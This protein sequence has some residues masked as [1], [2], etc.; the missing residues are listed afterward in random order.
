MTP[1]AAQ[2]M[3][4]DDP[5]SPDS[6]SLERVRACLGAGVPTGRNDEDSVRRQWWA[7]LATLQSDCLLP[8]P[9]QAG[10]W[11]A[12][13]LPALYEPELLAR[14]RGWVWAPPQ[15]QTLLGAAPPLLA[16]AGSRPMPM[17]SGFERLPLGPDDGTDPLLIVITPSLQVA[18]CLDGPSTARRLVARFEP[19]VLSEAL[20]L[21]HARLAATTP[22]SAERLEQAMRTLGPLQSDPE[23]GLRFWPQLADRLAAMAPSVTLQ[24]LVQPSHNQSESGMEAVSGELALLE[25]LT[26]EVRT[27]LAT[28]RTLIRS[29]LRRRDLSTVVRQRLEHIDGECSEQIDRFGLIFLAAE[30]QNRPSPGNHGRGAE[31]ELAR[32]DLSALLRQL[33]PLWQRQ[34]A[35]RGLEL[36]LAISADLPAVL[37]DPARLETM[38]GGLI[39]RFSR[40]LPSG[41]SVRLRLRAAGPRLK[42]QLDSPAA[43][44]SAGGGG[45]HDEPPVQAVGPVLSWNPTTGSLQLSRQATQRLFQRLGGRLTERDGSGLTVFFPIC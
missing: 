12:A 35:R 41:S 22:A 26:H 13:P 5:S 42:L 18:L 43:G 44:A 39:D 25:A 20:G 11:L 2:A 29:L 24:P 6:V 21:I 4:P 34:L 17:A 36:Q 1:A 3:G 16:G 7:A 32:T 14:L 8:R 45:G 31:Q 33:E 9:D 40:S 30:L 19:A 10:V 37:S 15:L 38:L 28:I 23:L 27:P